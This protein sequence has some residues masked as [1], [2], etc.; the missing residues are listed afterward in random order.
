MPPLRLKFKHSDSQ[1]ISRSDSE[2][3]AAINY[4]SDIN[5]SL[6]IKTVLFQIY[7]SCDIRFASNWLQRKCWPISELKGFAVLLVGPSSLRFQLQSVPTVQTPNVKFGVP[8]V[9]SFDC[10]AICSPLPI[11][12]CIWCRDWRFSNCDEII[13]LNKCMKIHNQPTILIWRHDQ[14]KL[15]LCN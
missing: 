12:K 3:K 13:C 6:E 4:E 7:I 14:M 15:F 10:S 1:I 9:S 2:T 5:V 8:A 11:F